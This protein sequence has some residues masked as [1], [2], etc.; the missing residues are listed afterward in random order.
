MRFMDDF[1]ILGRL[2]SLAA[3]RAVDGHRPDANARQRRRAPKDPGLSADP[4][5]IEGE[6]DSPDHQL[7]ELA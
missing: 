6:E 7:D 3:T 2:E 4:Q 5:L 1:P